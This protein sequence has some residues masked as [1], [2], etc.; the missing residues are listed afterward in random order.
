MT[1]LVLDLDGT[2]TKSDN[3]VSFSYFMMKRRRRFILA[4]PLLVL[5]KIRLI[6]NT[7][8]KKYYAKLIIKG[9]DENYVKSRARD[10]VNSQT[11][12]NDLNQ[13]LLNFIAKYPES[14][15]VVISANFDFLVAPICEY[16]A[17]KDFRAIELEIENGQY[18][19]SI[20][21]VIPYGDD[22]ISAFEDYLRNFDYKTTIGLAD[23]PSDLPLLKYLD[24]GFF[25]S[26]NTNNNQT[27]ITSVKKG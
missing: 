14:A 23:S 7:K 3:L 20:L 4:L 12:L 27:C 9:L 19:N 8:F 1:L 10:Y 24:E 26:C 16:L 11:F 25:V 18:T 15:K 21:G 6:S 17:I 5:L 22:K 2:L 13:D